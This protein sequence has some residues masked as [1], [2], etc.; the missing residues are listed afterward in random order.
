MTAI[1]YSDLALDWS[2]DRPSD[3]RI[4][5]IIP[6][7]VILML[8]LGLLLS[9]I[10]LP[11][12]E[13]KARREV[14]P[15]I[16]QFMIEKKKAQ[17]VVEKPKPKPVK[18]RPKPKPKPKVKKT[19]KTEADKQPLTKTEQKARDKAKASGLLA[20]SEELADLMDTD[21]ISEMVGGRVKSAGSNTAAAKQNPDLLTA[22]VGTGSGGVGD[23][24]YAT[25]VAKTVLSQR[26][27][28]AV[29]QSLV[30]KQAGPK[31][32]KTAAGK[33]AGKAPSRSEE[34]VSL[35]FD[36]NKSALFSLYNRAR[37]K[38]PDLKGKIILELTIAA[39]GKVTKIRLLSSELN[40]AVLESRIIKRIKNFDFGADNVETVTV[41]YPIEF[42]PS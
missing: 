29:K 20:L 34:G 33:Q 39:S 17:P 42:L 12:E 19:Q 8:S 9:A 30:K 38:N 21:D 4:K 11:P 31:E 26:E 40:D 14:P 41:T 24:Q 18:P 1:T 5:V 35:V 2:I 6:I 10:D 27:I 3:R 37:R 32:N 13:R 15:R 16:A 25:T 22:G 7:V 23:E 36:R 28:S